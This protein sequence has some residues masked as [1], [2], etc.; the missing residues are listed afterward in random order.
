MNFLTMMIDDNSWCYSPDHGEICQILGT[1][2]LWGEKICKIWL[3]LKNA[4]I[5]IPAI[6]L[7][8]LEDANTN[9]MEYIT[10]VTAAARIADLLTKDTLI[11]PVESRVIPLPHQIGTLFRVLRSGHIRFLLA[12]EVGLG[13]TIEAG[14]ILKELKYRGL[15]N[16]ILIVAP[17]GLIAQWIAEMA[18]RFGEKFRHITP[19][20]VDSFHDM[21]SRNL[22]IAQS[23]SFGESDSAGT[24]CSNLASPEAS[25]WRMFQQVIV[26]MDSFKPL[27]RRKGWSQDRVDDYNRFRFEDLISAGWDMVIIDEAHR[28]G[29]STEQVAR[30]K[31]GKGLARTAPALLLLS[32]TPHQGKTETFHRL[33]T[34]LDME[35]FPNISNVS[36]E[37]VQPYVIRN[38]KRRVVDMEGNPLFK[39]RHVQLLPVERTERHHL[40]SILYDTVTEYVREGYNK[41]VHEKRQYI[42]FLLLLMQRLVA[43][44]TVAIKDALER[45]LAVLKEP[46]QLSLFPEIDFEELGDMDGQQQLDTL[47]QTKLLAFKD[48]QKE[49]RLLLDAANKCIEEAPDIKAET[50]LESIYRIQ[51]EENTSEIKVLIFTEFISTQRMLQTYMSDRGLRVVCLNGN[52]SIQE[53]KNAEA[54]FAGEIP[55]MISTD[56]GGE[57]LNL[58]FCHVVFN[59]DIPWNPMKLEQRIGRVDRIGQTHNVRAVNFVLKDSVEHRVQEVLE[60]KL[61]I[62]LEE[63]GVDKTADVL[64]SSQAE[65]IFDEL[66]M[67]AIAHPENFQQAVDVAVNRVRELAYQE[68]ANSLLSS[69]E[70]ILPLQKVREQIGHPVSV[71]IERMTIN[72]VCSRGGKVINQD[73]KWKIIWPDGITMKN[74]VFS[75]ASDYENHSETVYLTLDN[76][77]IRQIVSNL[78]QYIPGL[79]AARILLKGIPKDVCGYWSIWE[80]N[81]CAED[82][83]QRRI[84]PLFLHDD[85]RCLPPTANRIWDILVSIPFDDINVTGLDGANGKKQELQEI[86]RNSYEKAEIHGKP[87]YDA[88]VEEHDKYLSE[89]QDRFEHGF[90]ARRQAAERIGLP[91]VKKR[92]FLELEMEH[93]AWH[94]KFKKKMNA[95]PELKA[96]LLVRIDGV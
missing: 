2:T 73:G 17:K 75:A 19:E 81:L 69:E 84:M 5:H 18:F 20:S 34:L 32:G 59:Y 95:Q 46:E 88:L 12:D 50:L 70:K 56:A 54:Q 80:V 35:A 51:V 45:R 28:L 9:S 37:R 15:I 29:G 65:E 48:E 16:R 94:I 21:S 42:G 96:L 26:S 55:I 79:P 67:K 47:L 43:S 10:Y 58:Q 93:N 91:A 41:A 1:Q 6:T 33:M 8:P 78:P 11:A 77:R 57:G 13:K 25:P 36:K 87:L 92:R 27:R 74:I 4:V 66:H 23:E 40:Q 24:S 49:V 22:S 72:Y 31:L 30:H 3:P 83:K 14:L 53:R 61:K 44:S 76:T 90:E 85:G 89:V 62:I 68:R 64:D 63:F 39:P 86:F 71:W 38:E 60:E 52:M 7:K 82:W